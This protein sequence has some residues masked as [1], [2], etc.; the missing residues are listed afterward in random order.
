LTAQLT[1]KDLPDGCHLATPGLCAMHTKV[2]GTDMVFVD[3]AGKN[4]SIP[5]D[6]EEE[7]DA[8]IQEEYFQRAL[9]AELC[10]NVLNVVGKMT[11]AEQKNLRELCHQMKGSAKGRDQDGGGGV[12]FTVHNW[13]DVTSKSGFRDNLEEICSLFN[14]GSTEAARAHTV[15]NTPGTK[16]KTAEGKQGKIVQTD[17]SFVHIQW[18]S[19]ST[20]HYHL[21]E[22]G[23]LVSEKKILQLT[24]KQATFAREVKEV[25]FLAQGY[26]DKSNTESDEEYPELSTALDEQSTGTKSWQKKKSNMGRRKGGTGSS[27]MTLGK[28]TTISGYMDGVEQRHFFLAQ[29][30]GELKNDINLPTLQLLKESLVHSTAR[31]TGL[32]GHGRKKA[33]GH[34]NYV[35][36]FCAAVERIGPKYFKIQSEPNKQVLLSLSKPRVEVPNAKIAQGKTGNNRDSAPEAHSA[37]DMEEVA[38][39]RHECKALDLVL[40]PEK[41]Y[42]VVIRAALDKDFRDFNQQGIECRI[43][44]DHLHEDI[45]KKDATNASFRMLLDP[46]SA[47]FKA[48]VGV[49]ED[50]EPTVQTPTNQGDTKHS[51][52]INGVSCP[53]DVFRYVGVGSDGNATCRKKWQIDVP[54]FTTVNNLAVDKPRKKHR[55]IKAAPPSSSCTTPCVELHLSNLK[56]RAGEC[57]DHWDKIT[58]SEARPTSNKDSSCFTFPVGFNFDTKDIQVEQKDGMLTFE[59]KT[60]GDEESD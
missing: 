18:D 8:A 3:T 22:W 58:T 10:P 26:D 53:Y 20:D 15:L 32:D 42:D 52:M 54:G 41:F 13:R 21:Q 5:M 12:I 47:K 7:F 37:R 40:V 16:I 44:S 19:D 46:Q 31:T 55:D 6:D 50:P 11:R 27:K 17:G 4:K 51:I 60:Q 14:A 57:D 2:Q 38:A 25:S 28:V 56:R 23:K 34:F 29:H 59:V 24:E 30:K 43:K 9:V 33:V 49:Q 39:M 35:Q 48:N 36:Q 45:F 1:G